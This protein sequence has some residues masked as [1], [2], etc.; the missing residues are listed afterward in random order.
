MPQTWF[1]ADT[2]FGH[3]NIVKYSQRPFLSAEEQERAASDPRG[4]WKVS[5]QTINQHDEAL[6][7][8]INSLVMPDDTFW[9]LGDFCWG[10]ER[11]A[12]GYL[13]RIV[14]KNV[15]FVWGNHDHSSVGPLFKSH[16]Q[17]GIIRVKGQLIWLNHYPM[18]SWDGRFHGSWHLYGHVHNRFT[19]IDGDTP[20]ML[21]RDVGVDACNYRPLSFDQLANYMQ[22]RIQAFQELRTKIM[23][24]ETVD[25]QI[26]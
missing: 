15:H 17:Q 23:N 5:R 1:T 25:G 20:Y 12:A 13:D 22:P 26:D 24:G 16:M 2:H 19:S 3:A 8:N 10:K 9:I 11:E 18:R 6:I 14:C 21:T 4:H 7:E